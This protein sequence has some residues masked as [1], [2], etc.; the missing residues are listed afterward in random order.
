MMMIVTHMLGLPSITADTADDKQWHRGEDNI[1]S[2]SSVRN[3]DEM[4][5]QGNNCY[6]QKNLKIL[7]IS[8]NSEEVNISIFPLIT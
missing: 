2:V 6:N 8:E 1:D 7:R 5:K 3:S 4:R